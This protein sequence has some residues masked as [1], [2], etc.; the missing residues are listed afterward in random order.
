MWPLK[1]VPHSAVSMTG[2]HPISSRMA[3]N[4]GHVRGHWKKRPDDHGWLCAGVRH[5]R[6]SHMHDLL[7]SRSHLFGDHNELRGKLYRFLAVELCRRLVPHGLSSMVLLFLPLCPGHP[8]A[9]AADTYT[10]YP[11]GVLSVSSLSDS[12]S[13][14]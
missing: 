11:P 14:T 2:A 1:S 13:F 4:L 10:L 3:E 12:G 6:Q 5:R 8:P 7:F 9:S